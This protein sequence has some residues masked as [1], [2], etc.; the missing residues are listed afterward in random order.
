[1]DQ[2]R[3]DAGRDPDPNLHFDADPDPEPDPNQHQK[4]A[5]LHAYPTLS[6]THVGKSEFFKITIT[7][8]KNTT[9]P[10]FLSHRWHRCYNC[11]YF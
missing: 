4:D 2:H 10:V 5:D 9:M 11:K 6:L 3:L 8:K 1:M 7:N